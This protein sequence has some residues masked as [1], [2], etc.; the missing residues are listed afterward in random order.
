MRAN[1]NNGNGNGTIPVSILIHHRGGGGGGEGGSKEKEKEQGISSLFSNA[2]TCEPE[3]EEFFFFRS[4]TWQSNC[5]ML[6]SILTFGFLSILTMWF[7]KWYTLLNRRQ[8]QT[9]EEAEFILVK[10]PP[11]GKHTKQFQWVECPIQTLPI[12]MEEDEKNNNNKTN[13]SFFEFRK[14]R[15]FLNPANSTSLSKTITTTTATTTTTTT[16]THASFFIRLLTELKENALEIEKKNKNGGLTEQKVNEKMLLYGPN[17]M[18]LKPTSWEKVLLRKIIHPFYLFQVLSGLIWFSEEY[19][20]YALIILFMSALSIVFEVTTQVTND[21]KLHQLVQ[22]NHLRVKVLREQRIQSI[23]V[24]NL[25]I[26]DI[27]LLEEGMVPA[28]MV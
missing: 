24:N 13:I 15:H 21:Q 23:S 5:F 14:A 27:V 8:V 18:N 4:S 22:M 11:F 1:D 9:F 19:T 20:T 3:F 28:E 16:T 26:G 6:C 12:N 25:V 17:E 10:Y 2:V 7:P